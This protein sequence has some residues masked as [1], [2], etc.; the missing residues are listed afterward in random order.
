MFL[1]TRFDLK[2]NHSPKIFCY[3]F[4]ILL[5]KCYFCKMNADVDF[6][7]SRASSINEEEKIRRLNVIKSFSSSRH[8]IE[9]DWIETYH[10]TF[11]ERFDFSNEKKRIECSSQDEIVSDF[12]ISTQRNMDFSLQ[13][14]IGS[15][16]SFDEMPDSSSTELHSTTYS[17]T[18]SKT[19]DLKKN[20]RTNPELNRRHDIVISFRP[21]I[22][23]LER[24]EYIP[25][26]S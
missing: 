18:W 22:P 21:H 6:Y 4:F 25:P 19:K 8:Y 24:G 13:K 20:K 15:C 1:N 12:T 16:K 17:N 14:N 23:D 7:G 26:K 5:L 3:L 10:E 11:S 2:K 9:K